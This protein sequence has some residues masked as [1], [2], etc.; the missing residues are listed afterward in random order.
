MKSFLTVIL[1]GILLLAESITAIFG[2]VFLFPEF[3][4][5]YCTDVFRTDE[6]RAWL[7]YLHPFVL[8]A[9][10]WWVWKTFGA[11]LKGGLLQRA[12]FFGAT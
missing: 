8:S 11:K 10:L 2:G 4:E 5:R 7:F 1:A 9:G 12:V 3:M 6:D